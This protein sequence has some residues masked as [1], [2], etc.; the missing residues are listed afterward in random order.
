[1]YRPSADTNILAWV[2]RMNADMY[3][4]PADTDK[5]VRERE[6]LRG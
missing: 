2:G 1:L 4:L 5:D 6:G 3:R